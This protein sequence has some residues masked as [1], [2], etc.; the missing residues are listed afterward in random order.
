MDA[1]LRQRASGDVYSSTFFSI[2]L[3]GSVSAGILLLVAWHVVVVATGL[4]TLELMDRWLGPEEGGEDDEAA[5]C[6]QHIALPI[7][8]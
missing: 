5:G 8:R 4:G 1:G 2:V 7:S 3:C 6:P